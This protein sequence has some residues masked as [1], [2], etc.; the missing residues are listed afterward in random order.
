VFGAAPLPDPA[1]VDRRIA[2][3]IAALAAR[4]PGTP[5]HRAARDPARAPLP[6]MPEP[7]R[8]RCRGAVLAD[9]TVWAAF[10]LQGR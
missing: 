6:G 10:G 5:E 2:A 1:E 9:P 3:A 7:L 8:R 4:P